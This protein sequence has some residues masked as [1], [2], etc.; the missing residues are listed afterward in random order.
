MNIRPMLV[1]LLTGLLATACGHKAPPAPA[2]PATASPPP[3]A[4]P[5]P[6]APPQAEAR[7]STVTS[8]AK[9]HSLIYYRVYGRGE[10]AL[11]FIHGWSANSGYWDQQLNVFAQKY[12]VVTLDL[13][14]HG[15]SEWKKRKDWSMANFGA[16]V[17]AVANA[18]GASRLILVGHSMGGAVALAAAQR[19]PG[20]VI[21]IVG[22][23]TLREIAVPTPPEQAK[24]M[25]EAMH[26]D[27]P[28][29]TTDLLSNNY[30]TDSSDPVIKQ[31]II[32]NASA[33]RPKVAIAALEGFLAMD[34]RRALAGLDLPIV[35]INAEKPPTDEAGIRKLAPRFQLVLI[36]G[37]GHFLML[38]KPQEFNAALGRVV[39]SWTR[40]EKKG[41]GPLSGA[42]PTG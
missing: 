28:K 37:V 23:D 38:E 11:V 10:P 33:A 17:A 6:P 15:K 7:E 13:A 9:D 35:A 22:V 8:L 16:D 32:K 36:P 41:P 29:A 40:A 27:F 3:L 30:F 31:W 4:K 5:R 20:K 34:Y 19:L 18:V 39:E 25:L 1:A 26:K 42:S 24:S 14:G 2:K 12:T 21:G